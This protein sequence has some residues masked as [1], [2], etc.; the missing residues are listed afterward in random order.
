MD[1]ITY[2]LSRIFFIVAVGVVIWPLVA[3]AYNFG[4]TT[5]SADYNP[6]TNGTLGNYT[7]WKSWWIKLH[8]NN[9]GTLNGGLCGATNSVSP[10]TAKL[11]NL[12]TNTIVYDQSTDAI[13][14]YINAYSWWNTSTLTPKETKY[15]GGG[16]YQ[17]QGNNWKL[18]LAGGYT[19][20]YPSYEGY[21]GTGP[22]FTIDP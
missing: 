14:S 22:S 18:F 10:L 6:K 9:Q 7:I 20:W 16:N 19:D 13:D 2:W 17:W 4:N 8:N 1:R 12:S 15:L 5:A 3:Y 11:K 21:S